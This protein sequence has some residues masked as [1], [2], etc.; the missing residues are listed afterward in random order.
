MQIMIS[1]KYCRR[2]ASG[3]ISAVI[4]VWPGISAESAS[5]PNFAPTDSVGWISY[6]PEFIPAPSG[7][8]PVTF[9]PAHPFINNA[10]EYNAARPGTRDP[11]QQPT[12]PVADLTNPSLQPWARE[13]LRKLNERVLAGRPLYSRESSCLPMGVPGFLLY[14][15][16]PVFFLQTPREVVMIA[17]D[18][19]QVRHVYL[20]VPH[21]R[22]PK[23]TWYGESVGRYEGNTLVVDTIGLSTKAFVDN[24]RT[25]HT[26]K[27]HVIERFQMIE[28]GKTLEVKVH[29]EDPDAFTIPW[30]VSQRYVRSDLRPIQERTCTENNAN[31]FNLEIEPTPIAEKPDF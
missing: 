2:A 26:E 14:V 28:D 16:N 20:N 29:I 1:G 23:P 7:P 11:S 19:I 24:Y 30:D 4:F 12:F 31:F 5:V 13:D 3:L 27:L 21:S 25:P 8:Q 9:D 10:I 17:T 18:D 6:G 22:N 15:V